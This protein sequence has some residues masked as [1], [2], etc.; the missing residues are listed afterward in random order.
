MTTLDFRIG[1]NPGRLLSDGVPYADYRAA[2]ELVA[3]NP[4]ASWFDFWAERSRH[5]ERLARE[6]L[7]AGHTATA[8]EWLWLA[9]LGSQ[10]A[11][12]I[13][14]HEPERREAEQRRKVELYR[15][16]APHLLP[17]A[18]RLDVPFEGA[19]IPGYLRLPDRRA[20]DAPF[21]CVVL[22]GGLE[23][24]KEESYLFENL[25]LSRGLA[26]VTFDG[27]GQGE[28][29]FDVKLGPD[30]HRYTSA[31]VD[32]I[33]ELPEID[34]SRLGVLGRSL[35]GYYAPL[36]A[37]ADDRFR[38]CVAWGGCFKMTDF[39]IMPEHISRGFLYVS[40]MTDREEGRQFLRETIDLSPVAAD[41]RCPTMIMHGRQDAIFSMDQVEMF[42][43]NLVNAPVEIYV[44]DEGIHCAH[45]LWHVVRPRMVD[46]LVDH[47]GDAA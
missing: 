32:H 2:E 27:P 41:I 9:C 3:S 31:V 30:F 44:E 1:L 40:G 28:L 39:D 19:T 35:G 42:E 33:V 43:K 17:P 25:C 47:I 26:T 5:Y 4:D 21:A 22:I 8:G 18:Q 11:Q 46:F 36:S 6:T 14:F 34:A 12:F 29:F 37:A 24:T 13:W 20:A 38:V 16:A 23:S 10:Y 7:A 15:E 45:N